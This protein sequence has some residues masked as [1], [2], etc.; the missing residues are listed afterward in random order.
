MLSQLLAATLLLASGGLVQAR[1]ALFNQ[2]ISTATGVPSI[3]A[4]VAGCKGSNYLNQCVA[5][6]VL[7]WYGN[8]LDSVKSVQIGKYDCAIVDRPVFGINCKMPTVTSSDLGRP[9]TIYLTS[10]KQYSTGYSANYACPSCPSSTGGSIWPDDDDYGYSLSGLAI[11]GWV[12]FALI[13]L[14]ILICIIMCIVK[15]RDRNINPY[16]GMRVERQSNGGSIPLIMPVI[17]PMMQPMMPAMQ[18]Q[19]PPNYPNQYAPPHQLDQRSAPPSYQ[20]YQPPAPYNIASQ[21][22]KVIDITDP[23][24]FRRL[25][26]EAKSK[27]QL[28]IVDYYATWCPPCQEI[29]PE[30]DKLSMSQPNVMFL[31][32][33]VDRHQ[34]L[35]S[36]AEIQSMPTF[37]FWVNSQMVDRVSG[38]DLQA[39]IAKC[40]QWSKKASKP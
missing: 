36:G 37:V 23:A 29:G 21:S 1:S 39:V 5:G 13:V 22:T 33:D 25:L 38:A 6:N 30:M 4:F 20:Q 8:D 24:T 14:A 15:C 28:C 34:M 31:K 32:V 7:Q 11:F 10:D 40:E 3:Q 9:L 19:A 26:N 17:Q 27:K 18:Q 35:A 16:A 12:M 2:S